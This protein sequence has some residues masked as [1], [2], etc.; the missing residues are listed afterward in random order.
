ML[1]RLL[2]VQTLRRSMIYGAN[3]VSKIAYYTHFIDYM[4]LCCSSGL[5]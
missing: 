5:I 1:I 2:R 4:V 3:F